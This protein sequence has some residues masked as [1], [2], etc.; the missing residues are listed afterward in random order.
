MEETND[1]RQISNNGYTECSVTENKMGVKRNR[2]GLREHG[3]NAAVRS[4]EQ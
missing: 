1:C 2:E 3:G 4:I